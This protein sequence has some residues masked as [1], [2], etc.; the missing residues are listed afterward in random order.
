MPKKRDTDSQLS[1]GIG[2]YS[3]IKHDTQPES[4]CI[5]VTLNILSENAPELS[6]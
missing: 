3:I 6:L 4:I 1:P 2:H 5:T